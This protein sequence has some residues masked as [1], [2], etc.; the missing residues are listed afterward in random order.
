MAAPKPGTCASC[1]FWR[2][3]SKTVLAKVSDKPGAA[4]IELRP[5]SWKPHPT[6]VLDVTL[7]TIYTDEHFGCDEW[8]ENKG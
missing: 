3:D 2:D 1:K 6:L 7:K 5:C 4:L 8:Q